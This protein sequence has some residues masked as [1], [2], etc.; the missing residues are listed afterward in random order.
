MSG[1]SIS[2]YRLL[3][4]MLNEGLPYVAS[5]LEKKLDRPVIITDSIGRVH[6]P[7]EPGTPSQLEDVF[8]KIPEDLKEEKYLY[9]ESNKCLFYHVGRNRAS[10]Y[11]IVKNLPKTM[12]SKAVSVINET[13]LAVKYYFSNQEKIAEDQS[14]FRKEIVEYLFFK[15]NNNIRDII[16]L[17]QNDL[18]SDKPYLVTRVEADETD[19]V[20]DWEL[21][22]SCTRQHFK[23]MNLEILPVPWSNC[24]LGIIPAS[25]KRNTLELD[26]EWTEQIQ[27]NSI[28]FKGIISNIT[29]KAI[30][31]GIG[32]AYLLTDLHKSY[33][34]A[35]IALILS[36]LLGRK[37][38][39]QQFSELG[40]FSFI[41]SQKTDEIKK[42]CLKTLG[43]LIEY[44]NKNNTELLS[45]LRCLA[46]NGF[47]RK[48]AADRLF[49]HI[50][51]M[52]YRV[53]KIEQIL[54]IDLSRMENRLNLFTAIKVWDTL[55]AIG[56]LE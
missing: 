35:H 2:V 49:I 28:K 25:F 51:T 37:S 50:N 11:V 43:H 12:V 39:V 40:I 15:C 38:F 24:M 31:I 46:D 30:S 47:N 19:S 10:A 7:D 14:K 18:V 54:G 29:K 4:G 36:R 52:H 44:D 41:F 45:T 32:Q 55:K 6:Y 8:L 26:P 20:I 53:E 27:I 9:Q 16:K 42:Y 5:Y 21:L 23:R 13:K 48:S 33:S 22:C 34:E 3:E 1:T 17:Y 56:F